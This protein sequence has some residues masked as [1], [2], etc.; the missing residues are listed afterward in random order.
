MLNVST[1][2]K[3][4]KMNF[5]DAK[6]KKSTIVMESP[7]L[8]NLTAHNMIIITWDIALADQTNTIDKQDDDM[9]SHAIYIPS[10]HFTKLSVF[11]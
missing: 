5:T 11:H 10:Q 7:G 1:V 3:K 4:I 2:S 6:S 9:I 8:L